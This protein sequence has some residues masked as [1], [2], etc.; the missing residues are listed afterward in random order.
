MKT[1]MTVQ[2]G[3]LLYENKLR[4]TSDTQGF[5]LEGD[6]AVTFPMG[7]MRLESTR[8]PD[9]GQAANIVYWCPESFPDNVA[10]NWS[11]WPVR[12]PG[13]CILFFCAAGRHGE[14]LF[15]PALSGRD[16]IYDQY[17]HGDINAYHVSYF[18]KT[19]ATER[20][21]QT[22]NLR[23]SYGFHMVA[24][25]A[26]PIPPVVDC[27]PPYR[28]QVIKY[29]PHISFSIDGLPIF[30]F[31]DDGDTYGPVLTGGKIGFRQ[32][33]PLIA[34]YSDLQVHAVKE[35]NFGS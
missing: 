11:F 24:Q 12:Q 4:D 2:L 6:G 7:R 10:L 28:M 30:H 19:Y 18:R 22:C 1:G 3:D 13:L 31:I 14:D 29:G 21:F 26:D 27:D 15:S 34:E 35:L 25:G 16:G 23:K 32:M 8:H 9:E 20:R 33:A 5:V 17:H